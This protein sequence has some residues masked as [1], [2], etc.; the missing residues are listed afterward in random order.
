MRL[1]P[2]SYRRQPTKRRCGPIDVGQAVRILR[3][4]KPAETV[5]EGLGGH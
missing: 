1:L 2:I 4:P 5:Q 3:H